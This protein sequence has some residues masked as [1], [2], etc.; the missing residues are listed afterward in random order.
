MGGGYVMLT[1]AGLLRA[2]PKANLQIY[3]RGIS[4]HKV[5]QL[6]NRWQD[7]CLNLQPDVLSILIGVNDFWHKLSHNYQGTVEI[8]ENDLRALLERTKKAL[9]NVKLI[10]GEPFAVAGGG[11][12]DERWGAEF[13][14][15]R[16]SARKLATAFNAPFIPYHDI[17]AKALEIAPVNYWCPD[18]VH[19]S[20]CRGP[21]DG[22]RLD[23]GIR[24]IGLK[25]T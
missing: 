3:N 1:A 18:G 11:A 23:G 7:D 24:A 6:A 5:F 22:R 20:H 17:F 19:P 12:I 2:H 15:Y 8:Y 9:P 10:I 14:G 16:A 4:G 13:D 25:E 21:V